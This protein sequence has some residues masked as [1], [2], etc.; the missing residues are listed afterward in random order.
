MKKKALVVLLLIIIAAACFLLWK[1]YFYKP[2]LSFETNDIA[3]IKLPLPE[4]QTIEKVNDSTY[5][6]IALQDGKSG[7][8]I[9]SWEVAPPPEKEEWDKARDSAENIISSFLKTGG[10]FMPKGSEEQVAISGHDAKKLN[11]IIQYSSGT[12]EG[13]LFYWYCPENKRVM[14]LAVTADKENLRKIEKNELS[15]LNCHSSKI[16][17]SKPVYLKGSIPKKW[18]EN[19]SN[20]EFAIYTAP[21]MQH[22]VFAGRGIFTGDPS[23]INEDFARKKF[24]ELSSFINQKGEVE[25][26]TREENSPVGHP[27]FRLKGSLALDEEKTPVLLDAWYCNTEKKAF[28]IFMY[29]DPANKPEIMKVINSLRCH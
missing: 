2:E 12:I 19:I 3:G 14:R 28:F 4:W 13:C 29:P 20:P 22:I 7:M 8:F 18:A 15:A 27:V 23:S 1:H 26:V 21:D 11:F 10:K 25:S 17:I 6:I 9:I 16:T 5:G 24:N